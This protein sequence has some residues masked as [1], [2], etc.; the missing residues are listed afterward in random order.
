[1]SNAPVGYKKQNVLM[2]NMYFRLSGASPFLGENQQETY[3]NITAVNYEFDE[4]F[5]N[6]TSELAKGFIRSL[7]VKDKRFVWSLI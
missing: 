4:E 5:F 2:C 3:H 7:L 1:M 6:G